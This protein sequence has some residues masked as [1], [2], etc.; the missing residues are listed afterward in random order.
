M[1]ENQSLQRMRMRDLLWAATDPEVMCEEAEIYMAGMSAAVLSSCGGGDDA[2]VL[3]V[4]RMNRECVV[5]AAPMRRMFWCVGYDTF[6]DAASDFEQ[7]PA[8]WV[9]RRQARSRRD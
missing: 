7:R 9:K 2:G 3:T 4:L 6:A 5:I 8:A 1:A